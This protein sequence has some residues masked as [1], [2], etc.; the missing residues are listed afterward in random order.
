MALNELADELNYVR[1]ILEDMGLKQGTITCYED[2]KCCLE[3][4]NQNRGTAQVAKYM[5]RWLATE[6]SL[7]HIAKLW[8]K[9]QIYS[10]SVLD[11]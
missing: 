11:L 8:H 6:L 3:V 2:N 9:L 7:W 5:Q 1:Q 10:P 4:A